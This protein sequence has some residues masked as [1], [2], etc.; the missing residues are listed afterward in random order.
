[1]AKT[2]SRSADLSAAAG[3]EYY[4]RGSLFG[5]IYWWSKQQDHLSR[6]FGEAT[7]DPANLTERAYRE[8][9][10]HPLKLPDDLVAH[11]NRQHEAL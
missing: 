5:C 11:L 9:L 3:T 4:V 10:S 2:L 6:F 1:L 8:A 7:L